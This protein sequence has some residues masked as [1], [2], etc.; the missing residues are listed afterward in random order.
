MERDID[1]L[2]TISMKMISSA[3]DGRCLI[4][5]ALDAAI[6]GDLEK[7]QRLLSQANGELKVA[8][9]EQTKVMQE[10]MKLENEES[11]TTLFIHAQDTLMT[12]NSEYNLAIN[13]IKMEERLVER[14]KKLEDVLYEK[15]H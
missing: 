10:K 7:S 9:I 3:G 14:I 12:I 8:H 15:N 6:D 5:Q 13:L 11:A 1:Q 4:Q 2:L